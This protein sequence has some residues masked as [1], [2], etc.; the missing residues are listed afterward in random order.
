MSR[1]RKQT[2]IPL[3]ILQMGIFVLGIFGVGYLFT[4]D[5]FLAFVV[6]IAGTLLLGSF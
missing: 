1:Q 2:P 5:M 4:I 6:V 3:Q